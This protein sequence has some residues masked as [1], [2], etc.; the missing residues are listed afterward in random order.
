MI[1]HVPLTAPA[2]CVPGPAA[3]LVKGLLPLSLVQPRLTHASPHVHRAGS[4]CAAEAQA[5]APEGGFGPQLVR[6]LQGL[7]H[8]K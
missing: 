3:S 8:S 2:R 5:W 1:A 7:L 4:S 6:Y